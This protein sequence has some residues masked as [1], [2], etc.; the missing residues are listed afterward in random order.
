MIPIANIHE[1]IEYNKL[2]PMKLFYQRLAHSP[3]HW[4]RSLEILFV[5]SGSMKLTIENQV[6]I[7]NEDDIALVNP[8]QIH[9]TSADDCVLVILQLR[10]SM[11]KLDWLTPETIAFE[12]NSSTMDNKEIFLPIKRILAQLVQINASTSL[13]NE[14][15]NFSY[16]YQLMQ[17]LVTNFRCN[18]DMSQSR[19]Q[20]NLDRLRSI[21]EYIEEH[22]TENITLT[23]M[24]EHE[25]LTPSYLSHFFNQ[26][27]G[28]SFSSY[29]SKVRVEHSFTDLLYTNLSI[30]EIAEKNGFVSA[31]SYAA[32]FK[33][34][35]NVLPSQYRKEHAITTKGI[36]AL[37]DKIS[38]NYLYINK[39]DFFD[40]LATYLNPNQ[41]SPVTAEAVPTRHLPEVSAQKE[42]RKLRHTWKNFCSVGR[43]RELL[44]GEIQ[45]MLRTLQREIGFKNIKFH[46]IFDD[47]LGVYNED[48]NGVPKYNFTYV[49]KSLDF[50]ISLG[51]KPMIQLSFMPKVLAA[52]TSRPLFIYPLYI[53]PPKDDKKW[54]DLVC[55]MTNH[56]INR[57]GVNEVEQWIFTF[58]NEA[59]TNLPFAFE[60]SEIMHNLYEITYRAVKTCNKNI[61]FGSTS[62]IQTESVSSKNKKYFDYIVDHEC[63]PDLYLFHYYPVQES[64]IIE[65]EENP[66]DNCYYTLEK[67]PDDFHEN[68]KKIYESIPK[69]KPAPVYITEWN[70]SSSHRE[71]LNDTCFSSCYVIKNILENYDSVESFCHWSLT[72]WIEELSLPSQLFHGGMGFFT[73]NGI[74]KPTYYAYYFLSRLE[75][76]LVEQGD[77]YFITKGNGK[78]VIILYNY[79]HYTDLYAEGITFNATARE[80]YNAFIE[81]PS[82]KI[83]LTLTNL[84]NGVYNIMEN[85]V[86][87]KYG[88]VFDKWIEMGGVEPETNEETDT[89]RS[90]S[91]PMTARTKREVND[92][93]LQLLTFMEPHEIRLIEISLQKKTEINI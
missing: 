45:E 50:L 69:E 80:R 61:K 46:G 40:K 48:E 81:S 24:A 53:S 6:Y 82:T 34:Y 73:K 57:Y 20:K 43:A 55:A 49:D 35:Y 3:M 9:E 91:V 16:S 41:S 12:C 23:S 63:L 51:L 76:T 38:M 85:Y 89:L 13:N 79:Q 60:S 21:T 68:I 64:Q 70:L 19:P 36:S 30:E 37:D 75:D 39:Y 87:R 92:K 2:L 28:L 54:Y 25:Y 71:W 86:N 31:R 33:S 66:K 1:I 93:T 72:D 65:T 27:M 44:Y 58:W 59:P 15:L 74:K 62:T 29:L 77:G 7:L 90:L 11:F 67:N 83:N 22:Y 88:S 56:L 32:L 4:H 8:N 42:I 52:D 18:I 78:Y 47:A 5:L 17:E 26:N 14:L 10:L 84:D